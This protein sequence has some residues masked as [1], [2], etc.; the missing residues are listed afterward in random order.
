MI[1]AAM[2]S[3][4]LS[5]APRDSPYTRAIAPA[6]LSVMGELARP[7]ML[8]MRARRKAAELRMPLLARRRA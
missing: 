6:V 1:L 7:T 5:A 4:Y 2:V 8:I 3:F